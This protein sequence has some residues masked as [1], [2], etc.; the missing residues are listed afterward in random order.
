MTFCLNCKGGSLIQGGLVD[1]QAS[2]RSRAGACF[3]QF[4][5]GMFGLSYQPKIEIELVVLA[6]LDCGFVTG[7]AALNKIQEYLAE[8]TNLRAQDKNSSTTP[9][10]ED[11]R[12]ECPECHAK[13]VMAGGLQVQGPRGGWSEEPVFRPDNLKWLSFTPYGPGPKLDSGASVCCSCGL[14]RT[15]VNPKQ[16]QEFVAH[17]CKKPK[18]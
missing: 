18:Q 10:N 5:P 9:D 6:C 13:E 7:R 16:L 1:W 15:H 8:T 2:D 3:H 11:M 4:K 17:H 14:V 12:I